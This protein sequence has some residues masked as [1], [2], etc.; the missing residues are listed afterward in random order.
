MKPQKVEISYKTII[1]TVLFLL[2][3]VVVWQLRSIIILLF[4]GFI[5][6][7]T[8][9]P[10]VSRL[11]KF[12]IPRQLAIILLYLFLIAIIAV[13]IAGLIPGLVTQ[14]SALI[15]SLPSIIGGIN[16]FGL[17]AEMIDWSSQI[18]LLQNVPGEIAKIAISL[19]SNIFS[20][21]VILVVTF[22]LLMER[23][24]IP[25]YCLKLMGESGQEKATK[26]LDILDNRLGH[27]VGAELLL[28]L[29]IGLLSYTGYVILGLN[30]A[31]PL[32]LIAGLLEIVPNIGPLITTF[33]AALIGLTVSPLT[34]LLTIIWA[35]IVHQSENNFITPK[36]M[37]ETIGLHP[38]ITIFTIVIGAKLGGIG[39]ALLA[40]PIY[41]I[42]ETFI[43]VLSEKN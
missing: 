23:K 38:L 31:L 37:K 39:G 17:K 32:A 22:Y 16:I 30:Y 3:L 12:K 33:F 2:S 14:T 25:Q 20:G 34:G 15:N 6:M 29:I 40:V 43:K 28:M 10:M 1:F 8:L 41:L 5:F 19:F 35:I 4:V 18:Q 11:Q 13:T 36:I 27:W 21:F 9:N 26:I 7:E 24:N 42:I